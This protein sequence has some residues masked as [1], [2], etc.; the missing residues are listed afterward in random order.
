MCLWNTRVT[1]DWLLLTEVLSHCNDGLP[2][3]LYV[4]VLQLPVL[5]LLVQ[6]GADIDVKTRN[7]ESPFGKRALSQ[8]RAGNTSV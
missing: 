7:G 3:T 2:M 1:F 5:E 4:C 6:Y 8:S